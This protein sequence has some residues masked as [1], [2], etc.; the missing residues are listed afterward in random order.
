MT[1][2]SIND[3]DFG[4]S[5]DMPILKGIDLELCNP[6]LVS[7]IGPNGAGKTTLIHCLNKLLSPSRGTVL[8]DGSDVAEF[9]PKELAKK[10]GYVPYTSGDSFPLS[11]V[12]TV[13][14]GRNPHRKWNTLHDD[15]IVVEEALEMMDIKDLAMRPFNELSAGQHQRVML[16]RGLAQEPEVLLL[17][18]P[19]ANLDIRHQMDVI[20]LLK[21]QSTLKGILVIMISHD[22]NIAAKYSDN[23]I[24][25]RDGE[26]YAVGTPMDVITVENM[27]S[28]YN[29]DADLMVIGGRPHIVIEDYDFTE[30]DAR[31]LE[32]SYVISGHS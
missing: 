20:R 8:I 6:Q 30:E 5:K 25:M 3:M 31:T 32:G 15:M 13:L 28:V 10:M 12:D 21:Q 29:V 2:L 17:D 27:K 22:I 23:I 14:M 1:T 9:K 19:T 7:I 11:V 4:Y 24:M 16:A 18:E 26:I